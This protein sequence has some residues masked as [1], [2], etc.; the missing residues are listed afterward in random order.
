MAEMRAAMMVLMKVASKVVL[1][2]LMM[3]EMR[4]A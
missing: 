3:V 4:A 2:A 1:T